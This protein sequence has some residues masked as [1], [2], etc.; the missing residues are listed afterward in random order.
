MKITTIKHR[1]SQNVVINL[2]MELLKAIQFFVLQVGNGYGLFQT[3]HTE[4][5]G[6][7]KRT[8]KGK[9]RNHK[10]TTAKIMNQT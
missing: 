5:H 9:K 8:T 1:A 6:T 10:P 2:E 3:S 4:E 7:N